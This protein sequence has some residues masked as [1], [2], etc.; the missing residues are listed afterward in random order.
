MEHQ[1]QTHAGADQ[2]DV[3]HQRHADAGAIGDAV[4]GGDQRLVERHHGGG[5]VAVAQHAGAPLLGAARTALAHALDVATGTEVGAGAGQHH[6][7]HVVVAPQLHERF[8]Q[9]VG[10]ADVERVLRRRSVQGDDRDAAIAFDQQ[11]RVATH[12]ATFAAPASEIGTPSF[13]TSQY[14]V[15]PSAVRPLQ[16]Y[17]V[18]LS[19]MRV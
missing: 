1:R 16:V 9:F 15:M 18:M 14:S 8:S 10:Q 5:Q 19:V 3:G 6:A 12:A 17:S 13:I 7:A 2:H 11:R 4:E